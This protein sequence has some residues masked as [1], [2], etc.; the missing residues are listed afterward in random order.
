MRCG[1]G[2]LDHAA[3]TEVLKVKA[4]DT[5]E[6]AHAR[7]SPEGWDN[8]DFLTLFNCSS[9]YGTCAFWD[10]IVVRCLYVRLD[11]VWKRSH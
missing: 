3:S 10:G 9:G 4:G 8:P 5:L 6:F 1:R 2:T 7:Q 11:D